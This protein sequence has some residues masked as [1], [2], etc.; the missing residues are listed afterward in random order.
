MRYRFV[1]LP[2]ALLGATALAQQTTPPSFASLDLDNDG[3]IGKEEAQAMP[4]LAARF[5]YV[6][7]N[8]DLRL[9]KT[10]FAAFEVEYTAGGAQD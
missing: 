1:S 10:E 2:F 8:D 3:Y 7:D 5:S 4:A 6:D 9:D